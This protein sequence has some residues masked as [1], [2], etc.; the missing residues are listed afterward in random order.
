MHLSSQ[1]GQPGRAVLD[2]VKDVAH[3]DQVSLGG[4][5]GIVGLGEGRVQV[6]HT[7]V[8]RLVVDV[9][10]HLRFH[11]QRNHLTFRHGTRESEG[12]IARARPDV[13]DDLL[14]GQ[15][16][17]VH[18]CVGFLP[19][20]PVWSFEKGDV[21]GGVIEWPQL[22]RVEALLA[23]RTVNGRVSWIVRCHQ[24]SAQDSRSASTWG[25]SCGCCGK[26]TAAPSLP[27]F[28]H[29]TA[30][31]AQASAIGWRVVFMLWSIHF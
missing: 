17:R 4:D 31:T 19:R 7:L 22:G 15:P 1:P 8:H 13:D 27:L 20:I 11:V 23:Q 10:D 25:R 29:A 16:Q 24:L 26:R 5:A 28:E 30:T 14:A 6:A 2:V 3:E 12:E 9:A 18:Y 21:L